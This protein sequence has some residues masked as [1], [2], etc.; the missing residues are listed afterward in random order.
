MVKTQLK[1]RSYLKKITVQFAEQLN[2][3]TEK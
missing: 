3:L 1:I 2:K